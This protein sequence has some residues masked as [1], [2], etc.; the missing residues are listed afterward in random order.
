MKLFLMKRLWMAKLPLYDW[1]H[2]HHEDF[3]GQMGKFISYSGQQWYKDQVAEGE[4]MAAKY[5]LAKIPDL[6]LAVA[7]KIR[8]FTSGGGFLFAMCSATDTY[9]IA[10]AADGI[11][12]VHQ[13]YDGDGQDPDAQ[14]K[15][16]L[17]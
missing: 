3:T 14:K 1:L 17:R 12:I 2:L 7:K 9:D 10:L 6:K 13:A 4:K 15:I 11:D 8:E 5:N 16:E